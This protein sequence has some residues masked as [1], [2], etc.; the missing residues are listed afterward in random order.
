MNT[1]SSIY[2]GRHIDANNQ[3]EDEGAGRLADVLSGCSVLSKLNLSRN[4]IGERG[5]GRLAVVLPQC[6]ALPMLILGYNRVG[7]GGAGR[8]AGVGLEMKDC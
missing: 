5:A 6:P 2:V 7:P 1:P 4:Q 3:I 8:L